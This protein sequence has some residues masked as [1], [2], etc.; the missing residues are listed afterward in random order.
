MDLFRHTTE[1]GSHVR[2]TLLYLKKKSLQ[3]VT[4]IEFRLIT[5]MKFNQNGFKM[6]DF[7]TLSNF[8]CQ[9]CAS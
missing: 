8:F 3:V 9:R 6:D 2:N 1:L 4:K 7:Q 5:S